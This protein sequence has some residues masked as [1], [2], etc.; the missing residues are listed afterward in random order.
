MTHACRAVVNEVDTMTGRLRFVLLSNR[1]YAVFMLLAAALLAGACSSRGCMESRFE[2]VSDSRLPG[3][4]VL[5]PNQERSDVSVTYYTGWFGGAIATFDLH[6][7]EGHTIATAEGQLWGNEPKTIVPAPATGPI[8][9]P[10]Y[11]VVTIN[12][13]TEVIEHREMSPTFGITDDPEVKRILK[14]AN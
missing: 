12:G 3:W 6:D 5:T 1:Q 9:Y 14:V 10:H 7:K 8:P 2:L 13:T 11:Q 4:F